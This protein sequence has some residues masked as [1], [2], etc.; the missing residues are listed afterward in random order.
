MLNLLRPHT[1]TSPH[2]RLLYLCVW[3]L[4][5]SK[6]NYINDLFIWLTIFVSYF[7]KSFALVAQWKHHKPKVEDEYLILK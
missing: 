4:P 3:Q 1:L 6:L 5:I 7:K 2:P